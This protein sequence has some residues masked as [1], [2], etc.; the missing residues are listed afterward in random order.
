MERYQYLVSAKNV[1]SAILPDWYNMS[2]RRSGAYKGM[3]TVRFP[4]TGIGAV[5]DYFSDPNL[6]PYQVTPPPSAW[7]LPDVAAIVSGL[8]PGAAAGAEYSSAAPSF[9]RAT[10]ASL[11]ISAWL[12]W[13]LG[14]LAVLFL[15]GGRRR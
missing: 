1:M 13:A 4:G 11:D 12:P 8:P 10:P 6:V 14:G 7:G 2:Y 15:I 9:N 3:G 5:P